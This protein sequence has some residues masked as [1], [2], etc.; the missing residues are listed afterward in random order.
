MNTFLCSSAEKIFFRKRSGAIYIESPPPLHKKKK[1][2]IEDLFYKRRNLIVTSVLLVCTQDFF[3]CFMFSYDFKNIFANLMY[4]D[5]F[6][7]CLSTVNNIELYR[8]V[9]PFSFIYQTIDFSL[10]V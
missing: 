10:H 7:H 3:H 9:E 4:V 5:F 2:V 1:L 6:I 8:M